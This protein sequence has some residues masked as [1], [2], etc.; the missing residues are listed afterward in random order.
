MDSYTWIGVVLGVIAILISLATVP[1]AYRNGLADSYRFLTQ[2]LGEREVKEVGRTLRENFADRFPELSFFEEALTP[3]SL[4]RVGW[5]KETRD[6]VDVW[7]IPGVLSD[8]GN[9]V[10][11]LLDFAMG[12]EGMYIYNP[13]YNLFNSVEL[14]QIPRPENM[15]E[16]FRLCQSMQIPCFLV[17]REV[18][19]NTD[20]DAEA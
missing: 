19:K 5:S 18:P 20:E 12:A 14:T 15:Y 8:W 11:L 3:E 9:R 16:L 4:A 6:G 2:Q 13:D 7:L 1:I 10:V 17:S